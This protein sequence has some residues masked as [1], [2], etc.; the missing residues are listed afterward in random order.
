MHLPDLGNSW[1]LQYSDITVL[2]PVLARREVERQAVAFKERMR[3][4]NVAAVR[5][6]GPHLGRSQKLLPACAHGSMLNHSIIGN[7]SQV[8]HE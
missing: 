4:E 8:Q 2:T 3:K 7:V 6:V 5:Q 1:E